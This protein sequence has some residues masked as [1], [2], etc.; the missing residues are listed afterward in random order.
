VED[1]QESLVKTGNRPEI[2]GTSI[3]PV[4]TTTVDTDV[5]QTIWSCFTMG[6][7]KDVLTEKKCV[8]KALLHNVK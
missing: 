4:T 2:S 6:D 1:G 5:S 3:F 8:A 7:Q